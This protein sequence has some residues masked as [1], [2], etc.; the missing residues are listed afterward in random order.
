MS[1]RS[2]VS[3]STAVAL[4]AVSLA[5]CLVCP[6]CGAGQERTNGAAGSADSGAST[7]AVAGLA[8]GASSG[9]GR[10]VSSGV[11]RASGAS[12]GSS[13]GS[14]SASSAG[15]NTSGGA[16]VTASSGGAGADA[17]G[18][19]VPGGL[20]WVGRVDASNPTAVKFAWSG[21][22]FVGV[23][24]GSKISVS[25]LTEGT[26]SVFFQ[27]VIDGKVGT[28]FSVA[29]GAAQTVV[30]GSGLAAADHVV[31]LY[32]ETEGAYGD[33]VFGGVVDGT[34]KGAPAASGRLIE[35]VGDSISCG[36]GNLGME[37][38]PPWDNTCTFSVD[39]EAA[40]QAYDSVTARNL[41]AE[42]SIIGRSGWGM[43]RDLSNNTA[44]V[45]PS[46]YANTVG[47]EASPTWDFS[48][49]ADAVVINLG[50]NDIA[51]GTDPG[52][53]FEA[54]YL[55]FLKVVR[56]HY[57]AA[58]I[59]MTIGPMTADPGLT[60]MRTHLANVAAASAD[61]RV[62]TV[63]LAVQDTSTTGC[64]YHPNIAEDGVMATALT[65]AIR[66]KLGW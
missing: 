59:F 14:G 63:D 38:H 48:R 46:V 45:L 33:T 56:G 19:L 47:T 29:S 31:E 9:P 24:H 16:T 7:A 62:T 4:T 43:Y 5:V 26:P 23:I 17:G 12:S 21:S 2:G 35:F 55:A 65:A 10:G 51:S 52:A 64:D 34:V 37:V 54:A 18:A 39:T 66:A 44:N 30:L 42:V 36:Y 61:P 28:R 41:G 8:V 27:P 53:P 49:K 1:R 3:C 6:A 58:W 50:T 11:N 32:R 20:R 22:G 60:Q 25:L 57:P 13:S 40:Y 15:T